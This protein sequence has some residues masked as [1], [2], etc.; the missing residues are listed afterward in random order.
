MDNYYFVLLTVLAIAE[1]LL[2]IFLSRKDREVMLFSPSFMI[3]LLLF[4]GVLVRTAVFAFQEQDVLD[5]LLLGEATEILINGHLLIGVAIVAFSTGYL[6]ALSGPFSI[7]LGGTN[8]RFS[9]ALGK[10]FLV[11]GFLGSFLLIFLYVAKMGIIESI[12]SGNIS[13]RRYYEVGGV[14]SSLMFLTW[15]ADILYAMFL[16]KLSVEKSFHRVP[17]YYWLG[18][19]ASFTLL[20]VSSNRMGVILYLVA[21]ICVR[22]LVSKVYCRIPVVRV[23][24]G[25]LIIVGLMGVL[26]EISQLKQV[27]PDKEVTMGSGDMFFG[28]FDKVTDHLIFRPYLLA[29]DKAS[30]IYERV[31]RKGEYLYGNSFISLF[32]APV[33]RA[34][35]EE[36]P[37]VR[38]GPF[39]GREVYERSNRSGVP[40]GFVGELFINFWWYG[41]VI[42]MLLFG[43]ILG[44][45]YRPISS[46]GNPGD[47]AVMYAI[48]LISFVIVLMSADFVGAVSQFVRLLIPVWLFSRCLHP[49]E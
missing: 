39:V 14:R 8:W 40:P 5:E 26:R 28:T 36:K 1:F 7:K 4:V 24:L 48:V 11:S 19:L 13:G 41:V 15:G 30:I 46:F 33:P 49:N 20:F 44:L 21:L 23:L 27:N 45:I 17:L 32:F 25:A 31:Q 16:V 9:P 43:G 12:A 2:L 3:A 42:G 37:A 38:I 35:W 22:C 10:F 47:L 18:L 29:I 34:F 6:L